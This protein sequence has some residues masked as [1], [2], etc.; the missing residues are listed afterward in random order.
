MNFT[1]HAIEAVRQ[2]W[3]VPHTIRD[4]TEPDETV[5]QS[6]RRKIRTWS[7][8]ESNILEDHRSF[9][10]TAC[11]MS[12]VASKTII[13]IIANS[14]NDNDNEGP[15]S[16]ALS[17]AL[18]RGHAI[19]DAAVAQLYG[20]SGWPDE[21]GRILES[22]S[23]VHWPVNNLACAE[24]ATDRISWFHCRDGT[25][26]PTPC[27]PCPTLADLATSGVGH[28]YT[29]ARQS[30]MAEPPSDGSPFDAPAVG[31]MPTQ[32]HPALHALAAIE[33]LTRMAIMVSPG[34]DTHRNVAY[35]ATAATECIDWLDGW[36]QN[37]EETLERLP[38]Y[39]MRRALE[40]TAAILGGHPHEPVEFPGEYPEEGEV[41]QVITML[42]DRHRHY[43][44]SGSDAPVGID[45]EPDRN[46]PCRVCP[47]ASRPPHRSTV[48]TM[49]DNISN[50][51]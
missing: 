51:A 17:Q 35:A 20:P 31:L 19:V 33:Q 50:R 24:K 43:E 45:P 47:M 42:P 11:A 15:P 22:V 36:R 6:I 16:E 26:R 5:S 1:E 8:V 12:M 39:P 38:E 14:G 44:C 13:N 29:D 28:E 23:F 27:L 9:T 34:T 41:C 2:L 32:T 18:R 21:L 48:L 37:D 7:A 25:E 4:A 49:L 40:L 46:T 3:M 10:I 30:P